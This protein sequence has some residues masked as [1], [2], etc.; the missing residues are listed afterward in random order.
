MAVISIIKKTQ[1]QEKNRLDAEYYQ[2]NYIEVYKKIEQL[3]YV[4]L[5]DISFI[6]DGQ[7]G[8]FLIDESSEI[9][10]ITAKCI[11]NNFVDKS[12]TT[13]LSRITHEKNL[14]SS[15]QEQDVL[16]SRVGTIG[17]AAIV[18][19]EIPPANIDQNVARIKVE[20]TRRLNP[21]YLSI[22]LNSYFGRIQVERKHTS[23]VQKFLPLEKVRELKIPTPSWQNTIAELAKKAYHLHEQSRTMYNEAE[24]IFLECL[25]FQKSDLNYQLWYVKDLFNTLNVNRLDAE[26]FQPMYDNLVAKVRKKTKV[27]KLDELVKMKKG[28]EPGSEAYQ[29]EGIS[30]VRVCNLTPHGIVSDN[31]V[32][33]ERDLYKELKSK[34]QPLVGEILLSKDATPGIAFLIRE[35][36]EMITSSGIMRL[37]SK[38]DIKMD[39]LFLAL[40]SLFTQ[41]QIEKATGGSV[42]DHWKP[43]EIRETLIPMLDEEKRDELGDLVVQSYLKRREMKQLLEKAKQMVEREIEMLSSSK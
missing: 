17:N 14:R 39:Y 11:N 9:R 40:N 26:F 12:N 22:F 7:H 4:I 23:Q 6:T 31:Q 33:L 32:Y 42:I 21:W 29:E 15:L 3:D 37:I 8:Y 38:S 28:I 18:T 34:Y 41:I 24:K 20:D 2:P 5:G 30:F 25:G 13:K 35:N 19:K 16:L 27:R 36:N 1:L 43:S 10:Q